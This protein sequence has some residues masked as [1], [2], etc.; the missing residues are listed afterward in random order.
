MQRTARAVRGFGLP[1][2]SAGRPDADSAPASDERRT[3]RIYFIKPSRYDRD[4]YVLRYRWGVI[5]NNT[6]TVLAGL[7]RE[8]ARL[9]PDVHLQTVLWDELVDGVVSPAI[10]ESIRNR[11]AADGV[12]VIIGIAGVQTNQYPRGRDLALQFKA[13]GLPVLMGG[14]HVSS[15][16]PSRAFLMS[17]G[18]T[19]IIGEAETTWPT[20]LD[21]YLRSELKPCYRVTDGVRAKT[22][23]GQITVPVIDAAALPAIDPRY[24]T[25]FFNPTFST[26]DTSRGCP[27]VCSY[28]SVKNVMGR[29]MRTREPAAVVEWI[30]DAHDRYGVRNLLIVDDDFFRSPEWEAVLQGMA[31][32]RRGGRDVSCVLQTD[33]ESS[34]D[35]CT[36]PGENET[37][38]HRRSRKFVELAAAAGCFEVFM[39]FESFNPA[40]LERVTKFHNQDRQDR[41][42]HA[43]RSEEATARLK[44]R[45]KRAVDSWHAA[46]VGVHCGYII[47][48]PFDGTG[49]G[50]QAARDLAEIGVDIASFFAYT[51]LPGTE[52][53]AQA[54]SEETIFNRDFNDY[55]AADFVSTHPTLSTDELRQE[56][57]DAYRSFYTWRRLAWSLA[58]FH[59]VA[60]LTPTARYGMLTQQVYFTYSER[61]GWHPMLGGIWQIRR[62]LGQRLV[63]WD[64]EAADL[65]LRRPPAASPLK[66]LCTADCSPIRSLITPRPR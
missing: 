54:L 58:T 24:L 22:G 19:A 20:V 47:G 6:L 23:L 1:K 39:G 16:E 30:R 61:G 46:G 12:E 63:K 11:G 27:F 66:D 40:N 64:G 49:C 18:V 55:D 8:Y 13:L 38:H 7:N 41:H 57:R 60:G 32:L 59:R 17:V 42:Q 28:C 4:G 21:D 37:H 51:P 14:F 45:Y 15:H 31:D 44:A 43:P 35:A 65:Y 5:P 53:Y 56:Y 29:T 62:P 2:L 26:I 3:L 50:R 34:V 52:D 36:A 25:R 10:I 9:R 48:M 33:I